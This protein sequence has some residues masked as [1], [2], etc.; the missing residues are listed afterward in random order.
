MSYATRMTAETEE[1][2]IKVAYLERAVDK[3]DE[4]VRTLSSE[5]DM[6]RREVAR[7]RTASDTESELPPNE[8]PPHY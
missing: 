8:K 1:L 6:I 4:V 2:E 5:L 7:L 3:L